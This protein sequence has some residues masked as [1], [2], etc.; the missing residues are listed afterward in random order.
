MRER[1]AAA[2]AEGAEVAQE[3]LHER[4]AAADRFARAAARGMARENL[5]A[6]QTRRHA[7]PRRLEQSHREIAV[8]FEH[9][10]LARERLRHPA[11]RSAGERSRGSRVDARAFD[12]H[13]ADLLGRQQPE[14][15]PPAA[16]LDSRAQGVGH[17]RDQDQDRGGRRLLERLQERVL[18]L[19]GELVG[20]IDDVHAPAPFEGA[21]VHRLEHARAQRLDLD[22]G[23]VAA[24][25]DGHVGVL[26]AGDALAGRAGAA[27]VAG[28]AAGTVHGLR[29][30]QCHGPLA[31]ALGPAEEQA[32]RHAV[33]GR[34]AAQQIDDGRVSDDVG[35]GHDARG[36]AMGARDDILSPSRRPFARAADRVP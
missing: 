3:R 36:P 27:R 1:R 26:A 19:I 10:A 14:P 32:L 33:A 8:L 31:D 12:E 16:R 28:G 11:A 2:R 30:G 17:G 22:R 20:G 15:Q 21:V 23:L 18:R 35:E 29:Q 25:E 13:A 24:V 9:A 7:G 5:G 4:E 6:L 34:G